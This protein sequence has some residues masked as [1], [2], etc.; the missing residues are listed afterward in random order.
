MEWVKE[1]SVSILMICDMFSENQ[2]S[3]DYRYIENKSVSA[4]IV[5]SKDFDENLINYRFR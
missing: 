3:P 2:I 5:I 1:P 4:R